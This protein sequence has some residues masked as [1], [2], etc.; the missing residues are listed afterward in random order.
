MAVAAVAAG[1]WGAA[2]ESPAVGAP[3]VEVEEVVY[4]FQPAN[5]G[6]GPMWCSG[7]TC[8]VRAG[9]R[10]FASGLETLTNAAPLNNVRWLLF[11]RGEQ[12]W[13]LVAA[14][15]A[16]RTREPCPLATFH[17]GRLFLSANP[18]R[19]EDRQ[20]YGGPARPEVLEFDAT[21]PERTPRRLLPQ[22]QGEPAFT[23]HSYRSF[24]ADGRHRE[25][26]LFQNI[27]YTHAE[28]AFLDREGRWS[29]QGQLRWPW[30]AEYPK[31]QPIRVCYPDVA[32]VNRAVFFCGVSDIVEPNPEWRAFK[33]QLTGRKW[34]Y[35]FRRLFFT[36]TPDITREPFRPWV[37]IASR[38]KTCGWITPGDLWVAPDGAVHL[39]WSERAI[40]ERLRERFFPEAEQA[41]VL[42]YAVIRE[43]RVVLRRELLHEPADGL[44]PGRARFHPA[45]DGG[46]WV[47][48]HVS[49]RERDGR[50]VNE[51]RLGE[52]RDG[53]WVRPPMTV[54]L[55][56]PLGDFF[57][58]TVRAGSPP[59]ETIDLLGTR[60]DEANTIGYARV[61][62]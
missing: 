38:E 46:L 29:A 9:G 15:P 27:G 43:G 41:Y 50:P 34:D 26:I 8:L 22:W 28:W 42:G 58:A 19:V 11:T 47:V 39:V 5:N 60:L 31:P 24:A 12:G 20:A 44:R 18:T 61:R 52:V 55:A 35:D 17:D 51:V 16:G 32:L 56:H 62:P 13:R 33:R 53:R 48:F 2:A 30:G 7:S 40:D 54:P 23:E 57:T 4:R 45:P 49:G 59:A 6:A 10:L 21:H 3:R 36:W 25:L 37:E 1:W 14:D